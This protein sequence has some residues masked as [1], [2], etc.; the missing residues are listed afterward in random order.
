[1]AICQGLVLGPQAGV[2]I[3]AK[4]ASEIVLWMGF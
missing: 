1:M 4:A 2:T 3:L